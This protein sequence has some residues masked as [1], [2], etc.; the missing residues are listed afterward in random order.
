MRFLLDVHIAASIGR[1]LAAEGHDVLSA[2]DAHAGW[3][4]RQL[5][6]LAIREDRILVTEDRDFSDLVYRDGHNPP[7]AILYLRYGPADQ[8]DMADRVKLVL[9][10]TVID[11]HM[12]VI[13]R[14]SVRHRPLP[15]SN[16]NG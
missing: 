16:D 9:V 5:L 12:V 7:R 13:Q 4:D 11:G 15:E 1:L 10:N 6:E 3:S 2:A 8:P 14:T